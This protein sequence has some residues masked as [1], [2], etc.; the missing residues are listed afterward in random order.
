MKYTERK[1]FTFDPTVFVRKDVVTA[2]GIY[3]EY[4][5]KHSPVPPPRFFEV[6]RDQNTIDPLWHMPAGVHAPFSRT[7]DIPAINMFEKPNWR[8]T[9]LGIV[10]ERRDKFILSHLALKRFDYFPIR[11]DEVYWIGYR[12]LILEIVLPPEAY[13]HQTGVWMGV[14]LEC[15]VAPQGDAK[16]AAD[17]AQPA[18][19]DEVQWL[20]PTKPKVRTS[21]PTTTTST[22]TLVAPEFHAGLL[23][24]AEV[25]ENLVVG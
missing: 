5:T 22:T 25:G 3:D 20:H 10:P 11:G 19:A 4:V 16:P 13:W 21:T 7:L 24:R 14:Y 9:A 2:L 23:G 15:V 1:E 18:V 8:M 6:N 12:Y 17:A